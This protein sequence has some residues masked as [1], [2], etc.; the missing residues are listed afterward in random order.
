M[1]H[2]QQLTLPQDFADDSLVLRV[3][4][5][6]TDKGALLQEGLDT[7]LFTLLM[8]TSSPCSVRGGRCPFNGSHMEETRQ[9]S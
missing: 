4:V 7:F 9:N 8:Q 3:V 6:T 1:I 2:F 5:Q